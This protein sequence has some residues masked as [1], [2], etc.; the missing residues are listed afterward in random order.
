MLPDKHRNGDL[1]EIAVRSQIVGNRSE[2]MARSILA[3]ET[4]QAARRV[5]RR[6]V[7]DGGME[8]AEGAA[9]NL[10]AA[11]TEVGGAGLAERPS[12]FATADRQDGR[13]PLFRADQRL[14]VRARCPG[15]PLQSRCPTGLR[16]R[17][18]SGDS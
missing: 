10:S 12:T 7:G 16:D 11:K 15:Q 4:F 14:R 6:T 18:G 5:G 1:F 8:P 17:F 3:R 13:L 2:C 9:L